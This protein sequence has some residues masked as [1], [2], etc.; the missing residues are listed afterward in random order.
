MFDS[1]ETSA[2]GQLDQWF[3]ASGSICVYFL[4]VWREAVF[5]DEPR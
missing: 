3:G 4:V 5:A 1:K 2:A